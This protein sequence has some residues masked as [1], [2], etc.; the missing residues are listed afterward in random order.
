MERCEDWFAPSPEVQTSACRLAGVELNIDLTLV[1]RCELGAG[2]E[3]PDHTAGIVEAQEESGRMTWVSWRSGVEMRET[4]P[5]YRSGDE[6]HMD[7]VCGLFAG[8]EGEHSW[9]GLG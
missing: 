9:P 7:D 5:A 3:G 8:H 1:L 2:H 6:D 4:C